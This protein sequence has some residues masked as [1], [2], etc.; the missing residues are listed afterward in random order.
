[1]FPIPRLLLT[2]QRFFCKI[3]MYKEKWRRFSVLFLGMALLCG[4][5][6]V[7]EIPAPSPTP[8]TDDGMRGVWLSYIELDEML[9]GATP[10]EAADAIATVMDTCVAQGLNTVFFHLRAHGDAYY[11]SAVWPA[12]D[13]ARAVMAAGWDPLACA[14]EQAQARGIALHAWLNPY[15]IGAAPADDGVCFEK[16][17]VWYYAPND[18]AARQSVL[19]GVREV[20]DNYEVDGIHFDDYFY[21]TGMAAEGEPFEDIPH[22]ADITR[23]RQT[24]VDALVSGVYGLCRQRGKIFGV[25]PG[26]DVERNRTVAYADVTRWMTEAGYVDY[27]CPQLYVGLR[28]EPRP[29]AALLSQWVSLPRREDV[30]LYIGLAQ[31]KV[32]LAHDPYAGSGAAEWLTDPDIIPRQ[33]EMTEQ[34]A[35][36][37]VLFRYGNLT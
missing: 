36:G 1:M 17:G 37:Y 10:Q 8:V 22:G 28:H 4:G 2:F 30:R 5:C 20:L 29:F 14:I 3:I 27:I 23:W 35:D 24:Q 31:Y 34:S 12:A 19:D 32:G 15:R 26:L 33:I 6:R 7:G 25:S 9:A 11:P 18:P 16:N 13:A 21:P